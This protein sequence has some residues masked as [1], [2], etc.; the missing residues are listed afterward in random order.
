MDYSGFKKKIIYTI[1]KHA[2]KIIKTFRENQ[3]P[4]TNKTLPKGIMKIP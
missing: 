4:Q 3:K 2:Q 1:N